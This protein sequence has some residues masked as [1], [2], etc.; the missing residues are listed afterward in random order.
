M[1]LTT[2]D[3]LTLSAGLGGFG[4]LGMIVLVSLVA[5]LAGGGGCRFGGGTIIAEPGLGV[6]IVEETQ[7]RTKYTKAQLD[8][9]SSQADDGLK[10]YVKSHDGAIWRVLDKDDD[11]AK[12]VP[13]VREVFK[14]PRQSVPWLYVWKNRSLVGKP[15]GDDATKTVKD[16]LR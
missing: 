4:C 15:L 12:D 6:L 2:R 1:P 11:V 5:M 14:Q 9:I 3:R 16:K 8:A 13:V 7:E 10:A